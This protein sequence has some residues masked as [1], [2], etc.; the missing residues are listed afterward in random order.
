ML[1]LDAD[2]AV[3]ATCSEENPSHTTTPANLAYVIYTSGSSGLPKG[4]LIPHKNVARLFTQTHAWFHFAPSDVWTLFHSY[5]FDFSV[6]ELWGALLYGGRVVVVPYWVSRSPESFYELLRQERVTVL[7]QTPSAFGQL[8]AADEQA[9]EA[10]AD[11]RLRLVIFGGERLSPQMLA[12]WFARH[13]DQSPQ[14]INMYRITETTVHVTYYP[15]TCADLLEPSHSLIGVPIPDL[16][17]YILDPHRNLLPIGVPGE[18]YVGGGGVALGYV[19]RPGLTQERFVD[20]PFSAAAN[21]RLYRTGDIV[22]RRADG[23]LEY[24]GRGDE[25]IQ[26]RGFRI[27]LGEIEAVLASQ[28][29]VHQSVVVCREDTPGDMRLVAYVVTA[30]AGLLLP[31]EEQ[32][33]LQRELVANWR[34]IYDDTYRAV[35]AERDM[36][37]DISGWRSSYTGEAIAADEMRRW[38]QS[39]VVRLRA[40]TPQRVWEIGCGTGLLLLEVAPRCEQYLGTDF[41]VTA[42]G[43][44]QTVVEAH[45]LRHV[46][47]EHRV[48]DDFTGLEA[49]QFDLVVLNSVVQYFPSLAYLRRVLEGAVAAL[50]PGGVLFVGDVRSLPLLAAFHT[51]VQMYQATADLEVAQLRERVRR[52]LEVEEELTLAP[53]FFHDLCRDLPT[54]SH[55]E[56][57]FKRGRDTNEMTRYR[58]DV[59][60]YIGVAPAAVEVVAGLDWAAQEAPWAALEAALQEGPA[61]L[62]IVGIPNARV[63]ADQLAWRALAASTG[64]VGELRHRV[65]E[66]SATAVEPEA[67]W[68]LGERLGYAVRITWSRGENVDCVDVL[69]E[70]ASLAAARRAWLPGSCPMANTAS[71]QANNPLQTQHARRWVAALRAGLQAKLPE[72]MIPAA[73]VLLDALPLTPNGKVDRQALP[74]LDPSLAVRSQHYVAPRS[75]IERQVAEIWCEVLGLKQVGVHDNFFELGGHSLLAT[76]VVSRIRSTFEVELPLRVLFETPTVA[77]LADVIESITWVASDF[78]HHQQ[79]ANHEEGV[80]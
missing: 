59:W 68:E 62:E 37:F 16:Q 60:L 80:L 79:D 74:A 10:V 19:N 1:C 67:L 39:T 31:S 73:F 23:G 58:Y 21:A 43:A 41:S 63:W 24:L 51:S 42:L 2:G 64:T 12:P 36:A 57:F 44:L 49:G 72:Y 48:A 6:W 65:A 76:Q 70:R 7:N 14:L 26:L 28:P 55:A 5:A 4:V 15:L 71:A 77:E 50:A 66:R 13:G 20:N 29:A 11:L 35:N 9:G 46:R 27:E 54:L 40:A 78:D 53:E 17:A 3:I 61:T 33:A 69:F 52:T 22:K 47:L 30:P 18:L 45:G 34:T 56:V 75:P 25:Q 8:I 38:Q 32:E